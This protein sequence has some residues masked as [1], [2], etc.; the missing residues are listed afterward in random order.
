MQIGCE[1]AIIY[2]INLSVIPAF[3]FAR[4]FALMLDEVQEHLMV[5]RLG[6]NKHQQT[7]TKYFPCSI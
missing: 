4:N 6:T 3:P 1:F 2:Y 7:N 5:M